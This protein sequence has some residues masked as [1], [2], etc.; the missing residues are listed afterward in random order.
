[1]KV[2]ISTAEIGLYSFCADT[3]SP[4]ANVEFDLNQFRDPLGH[5]SFR[6]LCTDGLP[7]PG[8]RGYSVL[9]PHAKMFTFRFWDAGQA[10]RR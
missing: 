9:A 3:K 7:Q 1:M 4:A 2:D 8:I 6:K 10:D 5:A